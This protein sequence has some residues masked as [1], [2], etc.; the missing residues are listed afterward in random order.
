MFL[1]PRMLC[2]FLAFH[3]LSLSHCIS[4][5]SSQFQILELSEQMKT[6]QKSEL[7]LHLG[8]AWPLEYM[9]TISNTQD[10]ENLCL[11]IDKIQNGKVDYHSAFQVFVL[12]GKI[13]NS[14]EKVENGVIALCRELISDNVVYAELRTGLK[15]LGTG[16]EGHL[17]AVLRGMNSGTAGTPLKAGLILSLRRDTDAT[18]AKQTI[19]LALK[20]RG[21]G[22]IGIDVSGDSTK[23]D[24]KHIFSALAKA[25]TNQL[26]I[27]LHIGESIKESAEQQMLE[28]TTIQPQ[29][30]GHGVHLCEEAKQW[31]RVNNILVELCLTSAVKAGMIQ[32][33]NEHPALALLLQG[34]PV[35]ICTDDPLIFK[36]TLSKE[37]ALV[38]FLTE[39]TPEELHSLQIQNRQ[40]NFLPT[41]RENKI[42]QFSQ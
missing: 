39:L 33:P 9:K 29:R 34:H 31:I 6:I 13:I 32:D 27:T 37:F 7:H 11:M 16:L 30:I 20:Y 25:K 15:D 3:F 1:T 17:E 22:V 24:G 8:G 38:S 12:I 35:A 14:D 2:F 36:T 10:F 26:P 40:Y 42:I 4:E 19:D 28:L 5:E 18:T 21:Q 41:S 23:G